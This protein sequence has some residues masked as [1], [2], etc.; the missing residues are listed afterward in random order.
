MVIDEPTAFMFG[1]KEYEPSNY[2]DEYDG[3]ITLR[4]AL[5]L[6][7]NMCDGRL[8]EMIGYD[9]VARLWK[10]FGTATVPKAYPS[11]ALGVFEAT[12]VRD[13]DRLHRVSEPR[14]G[15]DAARDPRDP[16]RRHR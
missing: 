3:A 4:R 8:A 12:P 11:I 6:S 14:R 15:E 1:E 13:R 5:A 10:R 2:E 7:R 9:A 16:R